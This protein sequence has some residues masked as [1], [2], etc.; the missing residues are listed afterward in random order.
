MWAILSDTESTREGRPDA[1]AVG[2]SARL[3]ICND[4]QSTL[5][6][7]AVGAGFQPPNGALNGAIPPNDVLIVA[8]RA[9]IAAHKL[10]DEKG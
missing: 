1:C 6:M 4:C 10:K 5:S 2:A 3:P 9:V 7:S 8:A